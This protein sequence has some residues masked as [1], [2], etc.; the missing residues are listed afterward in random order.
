MV[1]P[2]TCYNNFFAGKN[3]LAKGAPTKNNSTFIPIPAVSCVFTPTLAYA[4][5]ST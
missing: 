3:E 4:S 2:Q 5:A 1:G